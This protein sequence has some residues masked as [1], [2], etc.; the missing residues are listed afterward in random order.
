VEVAH[1]VKIDILDQERDVVREHVRLLRKHGVKLLA[2]KIETPEEFEFCREL[3]FD[4]FQGFFFCKP[5]TIRGQRAPASRSGVMKMLSALQAPIEGTGNFEAAIR[6]DLSLSYQLLHL[7][8]KVH[9]GLPR[10][11]ESIRDALVMVG[12]DAMRNWASLILMS[13]IAGKPQELMVTALVRAR[14]CELLAMRLG[15]RDRDSFFSVGLL[16]VLDAMFDQPMGR[17]LKTMPVAD[18]IRLALERQ[19]GLSGHVLSCVQAYERGE[20]ERVR[21]SILRQQE[22]LGEVYVEAVDWADEVS[23]ELAAAG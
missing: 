20:W 13:R 15:R 2:E 4:F 18:E 5:N 16:S 6:P 19:E 3:E 14:M 21:H 23:A 7:V 8:N 11:V 17:V 22:P 1:I 9:Y 10:R 12:S